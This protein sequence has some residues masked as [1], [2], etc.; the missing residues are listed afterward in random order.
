MKT[1]LMTSMLLLLLVAC[2]GMPETGTGYGNKPSAQI[3]EK[4]Q[5]STGMKKLLGE[6]ESSSAELFD[7]TE[8]LDSTEDMT[9]PDV[10]LNVD[11]SGI[12]VNKDVNCSNSINECEEKLSKNFPD[13]TVVAF[14]ISLTGVIV[15]F[16]MIV[17][18]IKFK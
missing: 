13:L 17:Y 10:A 14:I 4:Y 12:S 18:L 1:L 8:D 16:G 15:V 3:Y 7:P 6:K 9:Q 11:E 5:K 2:G